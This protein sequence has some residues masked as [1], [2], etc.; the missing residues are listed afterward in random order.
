MK[1][2]VV[3]SLNMDLVIRAPYMPENG[4]TISGEGFM[5]NPGGKGANQATAIG[6]LAARRTW[7]AAWA[8]LSGTS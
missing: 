8:R 6:K 1:I 3:G 4:V 7:S 5:T 2:Y